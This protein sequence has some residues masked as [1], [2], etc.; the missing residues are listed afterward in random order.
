MRRQTLAERTFELHPGT[1]RRPALLAGMERVATWAKLCMPGEPFHLEGEGG[2]LTAG[3][4][5]VLRIYVVRQWFDMSDAAAEDSL[6]DSAA[7]RHH[8]QRAAPRA[9]RAVPR[10]RKNC[11]GGQTARYTLTLSNPCLR[12]QSQDS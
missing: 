11:D 3:L 6:Y 4:E 1:T 12:V 8:H 5:H 10:N 9:L 2:R 7:M